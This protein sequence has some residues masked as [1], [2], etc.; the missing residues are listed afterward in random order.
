MA[1]NK[2]SEN[3]LKE[4]IKKMRE[5]KS[6]FARDLSDVIKDLD[7]LQSRKANLQKSINDINEVIESVKKDLDDGGIAI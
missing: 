6:I 3:I 7:N 4:S 2:R 1:I 5:E